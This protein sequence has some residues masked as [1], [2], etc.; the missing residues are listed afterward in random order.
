[1]SEA[2]MV[3]ALDHLLDKIKKEVKGSIYQSTVDYCVSVIKNKNSVFEQ[4]D[5]ISAVYNCAVAIE[6]D[7]SLLGNYK[8]QQLGAHVPNDV[9]T[10]EK[11]YGYWRTGDP[12]TDIVRLASS[13]AGMGGD[14]GGIAGGGSTDSAQA[15][16]PLIALSQT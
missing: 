5:N 8:L 10:I 1:M 4:G 13:I 14:S 7:T 9:V 3:K 11:D 6:D 16:D 2:S 15:N 12:Y